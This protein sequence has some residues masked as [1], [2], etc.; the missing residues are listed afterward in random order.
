[1]VG[2]SSRLSFLLLVV[3]A[4]LVILGYFYITGIEMKWFA[5]STKDHF[6][7]FFMSVLSFFQGI[8]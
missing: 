7:A 8:F 3:T 2:I 1:M 6:Y 4:G 5:V